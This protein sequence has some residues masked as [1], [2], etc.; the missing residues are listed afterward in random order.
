[1]E[2]LPEKLDEILAGKAKKRFILKHGGLM[3]S[4]YKKKAGPFL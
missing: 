3:L 1:M 4:I 2:E